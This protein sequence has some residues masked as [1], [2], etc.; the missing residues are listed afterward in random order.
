MRGSGREVP[1]VKKESG[2]D[3]RESGGRRENGEE[4]WMVRLRV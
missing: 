3:V 4:E 1:G 2:R